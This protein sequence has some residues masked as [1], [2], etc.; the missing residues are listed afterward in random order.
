MK[1]KLLIIALI[2]TLF[3]ACE[4][5]DKATTTTTTTKSTTSEQILENTLPCMF[6]YQDTL[7]TTYHSWIHSI[8]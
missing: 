6:Y 7:H 2:I 5:N 3:T 1:I 8:Y 4:S